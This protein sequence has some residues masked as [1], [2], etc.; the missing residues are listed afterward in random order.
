MTFLSKY[1]TILACLMGAF[2]V[3][4]FSQTCSLTNSFG[5]R[6]IRSW[7]S[8]DRPTMQLAFLRNAMFRTLHAFVAFPILATSFNMSSF[9]L[10]L[11]S[12]REVVSCTDENGTLTADAIINPDCLSYVQAAKIDKYFSDYDLPIA[13]YGMKFVTEANKNDLPVYLLPAIA[14]A[15]STGCKFVIKNKNNCFGWG[16]GTIAFESIDESIE[17]IAWNLGGNNPKTAHHYEGRDLEG[18][19]HKYNP[20]KVAPRYLGIIKAIMKAIDAKDINI[21]E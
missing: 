1:D 4:G 3:K 12:P 14:M 2:L 13:G 8:V 9:V 7:R 21:K 16:S 6:Q 17:V 5:S 10:N 11:E 19:V 18:I 15:E 20:P